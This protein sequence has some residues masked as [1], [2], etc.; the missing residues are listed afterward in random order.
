MREGG[1]E[2]KT[3]VCG[4]GKEGL[5]VW[6]CV[7]CRY[8][9]KIFETCDWKKRRDESRRGRQSVCA[10]GRRRGVDGDRDCWTVVGEFLRGFQRVFDG[11]LRGFR[12]V[13]SAR[14]GE[15]HFPGDP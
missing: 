4:E 3:Q 1:D 6:E 10:T 2:I 11:F 5:S 9:R 7:G 8:F 15:T 14:L 12:R 13:G